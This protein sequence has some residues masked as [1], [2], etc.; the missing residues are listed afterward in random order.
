MKRKLLPPAEAEDAA[1]NAAI[2]KNPGT[3]EL[4]DEEFR[5][6]RLVSRGPGRPAGSGRKVPVTMRLDAD[7]VAAF[8]AEGAA[9]R[10]G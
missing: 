1:S 8:R 4:S 9:G 2:A 10:P 7:V 5:R 6:L 3:Y